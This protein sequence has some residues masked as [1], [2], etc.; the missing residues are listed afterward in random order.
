MNKFGV[1]KEV[2]KDFGNCWAVLVGYILEAK[3]YRDG[4]G[5][6]HCAKIHGRSKTVQGKGLASQYAVCRGVSESWAVRASVG[7]PEVA[8][9][10]VSVVILLAKEETK[11]A[12]LSTVGER[13]KVGEDERWGEGVGL[14]FEELLGVPDLVSFPPVLKDPGTQSGFGKSLECFEWGWSIASWAGR[15]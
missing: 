6:A 3:K 7:E 15:R 4:E 5:E 1:F 9:E 11:N 10:H 2:G 8:V 14:V 12:D 13:V